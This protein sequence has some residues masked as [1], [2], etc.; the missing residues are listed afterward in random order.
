MNVVVCLVFIRELGTGSDYVTFVTCN[1]KKFI[2]IS[3]IVRFQVLTVAATLPPVVHLV[4]VVKLK[5]KLKFSHRCHE[6]VS[7]TIKNLPQQKSQF[8]E[9]ITNACGSKTAY[10]RT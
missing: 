9:Q 3:H 8:S 6:V 1:L 7:H 10:F 2:N 4:T 5:A